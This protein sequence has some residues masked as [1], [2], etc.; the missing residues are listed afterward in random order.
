MRRII[1]FFIFF[2]VGHFLYGQTIYNVN[3]KAG[4][5]LENSVLWG[6]DGTPLMHLSNEN[7]YYRLFFKK[8]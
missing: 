8:T 1:P 2:L 6:F 4:G 7:F 3:G 5:Y